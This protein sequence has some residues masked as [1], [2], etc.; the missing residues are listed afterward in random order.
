[1]ARQRYAPATVAVKV[2][3]DPDVE[4][5]LRFTFTP[6][7]DGPLQSVGESLFPATRYVASVRGTGDLVEIHWLRAPERETVRGE[8]ES[9]ARRRVQER[10]EWLGRLRDLVTTVKGWA[11]ELDWAA[12]VVDKR[13]EDAEIGGYRAPS[14]LLQRESVRLYLEPIGRSAPGIEGVVDLCLMPSYDDVARLTNEGDRWKVRYV[15]DDVVPGNGRADRVR[16]LTK[17][18]IR[19]VFDAMQIHAG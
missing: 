7:A 15:F 12:K 16:P 19:R 11:D 6:G 13:M 2:D 8:L 17:A 18:T 14:L 5:T 1:M 3:D 10:T 4:G 9:L